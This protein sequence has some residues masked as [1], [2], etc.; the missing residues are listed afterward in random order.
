MK[1]VLT[2]LVFGVT[3]TA[4]I[5]GQTYWNEEITTVSSKKEIV[6][7]ASKAAPVS[8]GEESDPIGDKIKDIPTKP[9]QEVF[10]RVEGKKEKI[11][12]TFIGSDALGSADSGWPLLVE[13]KL[14]DEFKDKV[15]FSTLHYNLT[16]N[17]YVQQEKFNDLISEKADIIYF[18]PFTLN[19]NGSVTIEDS[20]KNVQTTMDK[21][22][23]DNPSAVFILQPPHPIYQARNYPLQVEALKDYAAKNNILFLDHWK[24]WPDYN[25][26]EINNYENEAQ[27]QP[28]DKG[29]RIWADAVIEQFVR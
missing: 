6:Q 10:N 20:L 8:S 18:E 27:S 9:L 26:E 15:T 17:E 5:L 21:V 12:I 7:E 13:K 23:E 11:K 19:D 2:I 14:Q 29:N 28:N 4:I 3:V 16:S 25:N 24:N 22:H 1:A